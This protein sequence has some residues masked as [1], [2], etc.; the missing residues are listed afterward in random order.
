MMNVYV[1]KICLCS[2][3]TGFKTPRIVASQPFALFFFGTH[4]ES[5]DHV[6][7]TSIIIQF[8]IKGIIHICI[9][10]YI[11]R[12]IYIE[13][14]ICHR[15]GPV[16]PWYYKLFE[17][18]SL[19]ARFMGLTWGPSGADRTQVG[20]MLAPWNLLF[21]YAYLAPSH[22][23]ETTLTYHQYEPMKKNS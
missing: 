15:S 18:T 13:V 9:Y 20:P 5:D 6:W 7:I 19:I 22:S 4:G 1:L 17:K 8:K 11:Y 14:Y 10:I 21:G 12:Y 2:H 16:N 23:S 3:K